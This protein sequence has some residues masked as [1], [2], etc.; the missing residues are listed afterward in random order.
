MI[1]A[2]LGLTCTDTEQDRQAPDDHVGHNPKGAVRHVPAGHS[3]TQHG[4]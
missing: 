3:M 4:A 1:R 2:P